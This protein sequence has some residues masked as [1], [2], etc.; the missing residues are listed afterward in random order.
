MDRRRSTPAGQHRPVLLDEVMTVLDPQPGE[1]V[2]DC[3]LG[4]GGHAAELLSRVGPSGRLIGLDLDADNL[5]RAKERLAG[6]AYSLHH[7]NF[8]GLAQVF[9]EQGIVGVD[10]LLADLGMSSMQVDEPDR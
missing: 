8:A 6:N 10:C 1:T 9:G 5:A 3:T 4:W 7:S 2:V